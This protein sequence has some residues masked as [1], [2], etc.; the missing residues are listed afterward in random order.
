[1]LRRRIAAVHDE[2]SGAVRAVPTVE[3]TRSYPMV[4]ALVKYGHAVAIVAALTCL[5]FGI[6]F[7]VRDG[8]IAY[9]AAGLA[10]GALL[11]VLLKSYT[12]LVSIIADMMLAK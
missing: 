3:P 8:A 2:R 6:A 5:A 10:V 4:H 7:A 1:M 11:Y 12:E 9:A